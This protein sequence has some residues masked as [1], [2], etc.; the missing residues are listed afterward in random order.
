MTTPTDLRTP[1]NYCRVFIPVSFGAMSV[2]ICQ[3]TRN[4]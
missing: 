1:S 3:E 2:K 4:L